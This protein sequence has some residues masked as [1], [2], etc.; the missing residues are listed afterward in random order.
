MQE[1]KVEVR[2]ETQP[3]NVRVP[4]PRLK[5]SFDEAEYQR[6]DEKLRSRSKSK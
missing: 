4:E 3:I 5:S 1:T 2:S 6:W